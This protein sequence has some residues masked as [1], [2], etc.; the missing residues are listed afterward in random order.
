MKISKLLFIS[1][2][3]IGTLMA[4]DYSG[5]ELYTNETYNYGKFEARMQMASASGLVSSM[6]LYY[7]DSYMGDPE[8][9]VEIDIEVLGKAPGSFQ[10]N[11]ISGS[12]AKKKTSEKHHTLTTPAN[13]SYHTYGIE[14]TPTYIAWFVDGIEMRRTVKDSN[15]TKKQVEAMIKEQNLRFNL[16]ASESEAWVGAFDEASLPKYQYIN[17]VKVYDYTPGNGPDGSD[18]TLRWTDDFETFD[19]TRWN[20]ANWTFDGNRVDLKS[21]NIILKEGTLILA[22]TKSGEE[23]FND[24]E[25]PADNGEIP[26]AIPFKTKQEKIKASFQNDEI[27]LY[28]NPHSGWTW[29]IYSTNGNVLKTG[30]GNSKTDIISVKDLKAGSYYLKVKQNGHIHS[31]DF[32]KI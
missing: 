5:A 14:W 28:L 26:N 3:L 25:I 27:Q 13:E 15:D 10:S 4:K 31:L 17:W 22:L 8:P 9:W 7:N 16:W 2:S 23:G 21:E 19:D 12:A 30:E 18:F 6:F 1:F 20:K 29:K 24:S 11:I 32:K